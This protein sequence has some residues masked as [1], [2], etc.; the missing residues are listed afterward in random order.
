MAPVVLLGAARLI[1]LHGAGNPEQP[2]V[3]SMPSPSPSP[4]P[5]PAAMAVAMGVAAVVGIGL[6][7]SGNNLAPNASMELLR[8]RTKYAHL[9]SVQRRCWVT[10]EAEAALAV[11][12]FGANTARTLDPEFARDL[13]VEPAKG[14]GISDGPVMPRIPSTNSSGSYGAS[15]SDGITLI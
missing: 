11:A 10:H 7:V 15:Y 12:L 9:R 4:S 8:L 14:L 1:C 5:A 3:F 13:D 2:V 6:W